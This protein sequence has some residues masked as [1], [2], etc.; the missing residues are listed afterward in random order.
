[1]TIGVLQMSELILPQNLR[2]QILAEALAAHPRE[3]CGLLEGSAERITALHPTRNLAAGPDRFE[4]DPAEQFRLRREGR[5][6]V[7]CYHSHPNGRAEPS[8]RDGEQAGEA[9]FL[10]LICA[11]TLG[12]YVWDGAGFRPLALLETADA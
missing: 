6:I 3:C 7:G 11:D 2:S 1:M 9:G 4:I 12:A 8:P 10:W 5:R